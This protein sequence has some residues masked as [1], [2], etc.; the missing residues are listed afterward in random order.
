[1]VPPPPSYALAFSFL[2]LFCAAV[3]AQLGLINDVALAAL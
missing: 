1:M 3:V 2:A